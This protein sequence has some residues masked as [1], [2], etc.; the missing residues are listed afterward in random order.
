[1]SYKSKTHTFADDN[2]NI[3]NYV[4]DREAEWIVS[5]RLLK[6]VT[7]VLKSV[8][9]QWREFRTEELDFKGHGTPMSF[10]RE[11]TD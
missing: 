6:Q 1:M 5:G 10:W 9:L 11:F 4:E 3:F 8:S 2:G 7:P